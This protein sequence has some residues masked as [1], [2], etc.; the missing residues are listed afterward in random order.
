MVPPTYSLPMPGCCG[1]T[2]RKTTSSPGFSF[3]AISWNCCTLRDGLAIHL[4][5]HFTRGQAL[6]AIRE[7]ART[8]STDQDTP[9][10]A[11]LRC[12]FRRHAADRH[13]QLWWC[14]SPA[15]RWSSRTAT[16]HCSEPPTSRHDRRSSRWRFDACQL[17]INI[18][19]APR[20]NLVSVPQSSLIRSSPPLIGRPSMVTMMSPGFRPDLS[21]GN[22][23][24]HGTG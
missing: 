17:V 11:R 13:A 1:S 16:Y 18:A 14:H 3:E 20:L 4:Q 23:G 7:R 12:H 22:P 21:A 2:T 8:D 19:N 24:D 15:V 6:Q 10:D 9:V 5:N